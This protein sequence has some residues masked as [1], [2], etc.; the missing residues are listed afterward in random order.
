MVSKYKFE[1]MTLSQLRSLLKEQEE[2]VKELQERYGE[3]YR[4]QSKIAQTMKRQGFRTDSLRYY[5]GKARAVTCPAF[6]QLTH[7]SAE[8]SRYNCLASSRYGYDRHF[9]RFHCYN[10]DIPR[11]NIEVEILKRKLLSE[12]QR[13]S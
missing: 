10:C 7:D 5:I 9:F 4:I 2:D 13:T 12:D 11:K 8:Y 6:R 3:I 1:K